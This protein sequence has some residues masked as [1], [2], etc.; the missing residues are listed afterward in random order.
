MVSAVE[1]FKGF[2]ESEGLKFTQERQM[3]LEEI[4]AT[5][6]HFEAE[7]LLIRL[8]QRNKRVSRATIYRTLT[9]L[10]Q[11]KLVNELIFGDRHTSYECVHSRKRHDHLICVSCGR[12]IE[13]S[14]PAIEALRDRICE[15]YRFQPVAIKLEITGYCAECPDTQRNQK[16]HE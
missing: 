15:E 9:L 14:R 12:I 5:R 13:F 1:K 11:S 8:R 16:A 10:V 3:V 2:L 6:Q 4:L 7:A